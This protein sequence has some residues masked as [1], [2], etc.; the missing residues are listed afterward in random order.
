MEAREGLER[1]GNAGSRFNT[2]CKVE[3]GRLQYQG[4]HINL[5]VVQS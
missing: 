5:L 2:Y 4:I 1:V 3:S